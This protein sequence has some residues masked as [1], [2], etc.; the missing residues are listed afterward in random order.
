M[1][2][3][4][5]LYSSACLHPRLCNFPIFHGRLPETLVGVIFRFDVNSQI[6]ASFES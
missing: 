1:P 2:D 5:G 3:S 6:A 4:K